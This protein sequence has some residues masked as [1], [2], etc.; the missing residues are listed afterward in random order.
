MIGLASNVLVG[1]KTDLQTTMG[2]TPS[3]ISLTFRGKTICSLR[4]LYFCIQQ[5][6]VENILR[7][8]D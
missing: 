4:H 1:L 8:R 6:F 5:T 7:A 2:R 3:H